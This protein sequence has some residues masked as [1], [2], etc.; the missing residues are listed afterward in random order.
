MTNNFTPYCF[1]KFFQLIVI[2]FF[3]STMPQIS[4]AQPYIDMFNIA[5]FNS[6]NTGTPSKGKNQTRLDYFSIYTT[7]PIQFGKNKDAIILSPFFERWNAQVQNISGYSNYY[8]GVVLP[9]T[10]MKNIPNSK[11]TLLT[12]AIVRM[13]DAE[14]NSNG[15]WQFG[16]AF[17]AARHVNAKLTYKLGFYMNSE[18]F[19][20]FFVPLVGIDWRI[21]DKTNLFGVLPASLTLERKLNKHFFTG[22]VVRTFTNSYYDAGPNYMRVDENQL[23]LFLD[24]Y[25][26]NRLLL[27]VEVG[28]SILR[29]LR[30]GT[31]HNIHDNWNA[32]NNMYFKFAIAYRFRLRS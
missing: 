30:G 20:L 24:Y 12:T 4:S 26:T 31:W 6:P 18:F 15:Q 10:Y 8:Y 16:G 7:I 29:K 1:R 22:A 32:D 21:N 13:N 14:I 17:V 2:L 19:G 3:I 28:H 25:P 23:G 11:W 9:V 27:N 5:Y